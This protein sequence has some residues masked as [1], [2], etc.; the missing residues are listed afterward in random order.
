MPRHFDRTLPITTLLI[1][2]PAPLVEPFVASASLLHFDARR[3]FYTSRVQ[4]GPGEADTICVDYLTLVT[5]NRTD[6][7]TTLGEPSAKLPAARFDMLTGK[8]S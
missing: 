3:S 7:R 4:H 8:L 2:L 5:A 6:S 1:K